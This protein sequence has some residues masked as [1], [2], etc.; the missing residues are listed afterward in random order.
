MY[1]LFEFGGNAIGLLGIGISVMI[2]GSIAS[3]GFITFIENN[4]LILWTEIAFLIIAG[5]VIAINIANDAIKF[6]KEK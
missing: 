2:L 3:N 6:S 4:P 5:V 1:W